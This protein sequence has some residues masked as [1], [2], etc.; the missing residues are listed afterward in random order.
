M[1]SSSQFHNEPLNIDRWQL[2]RALKT[3]AE[4]VTDN[5]FD[6]SNYDFLKMSL[7]DTKE[8]RQMFDN[9]IENV[10]EKQWQARAEVKPT[11][12]KSKPKTETK[13]KKSKKSTDEEEKKNTKGEEILNKLWT[14]FDKDLHMI[15]QDNKEKNCFILFSLGASVD[16]EGA[17][18]LRDFSSQIENT[19]IIVVSHKGFTTYAMNNFPLPTV[20]KFTFSEL[21]LNPTK[22]K[23]YS[24]PHQIL[25][26]NAKLEKLN[27]LNVDDLTKVPRIQESDVQSIYYNIPKNS[28]VRILHHFGEPPIRA[29]Y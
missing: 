26:E 18:T 14:Y 28:I 11:K 24:C 2:F 7:V 29:C 1:T 15:L 3:L 19:D 6:I 13:T 10:K 4:M 23:I 17:R 20:R 21:L 25:D 9:F 22:H 5:G 12:K 16:A 27:D 8:S